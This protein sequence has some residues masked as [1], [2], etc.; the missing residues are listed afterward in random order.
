MPAAYAFTFTPATVDPIW[1]PVGFGVPRRVSVLHQCDPRPHAT[2][3]LASTN[4]DGDLVQIKETTWTLHYVDSINDIDAGVSTSTEEVA[5]LQ[6]TND[7]GLTVTAMARGANMV[8]LS[9]G[10]KNYVWE[11]TEG[12]TYYGNH[13]NAFPL[14]RGLILN[15]GV[16]FAAVTAEHGL[17]YDTDW[18]MSSDV[19]SPNEKSIIL[20]IVDTA[21]QRGKILDPLSVGQ[22]NRQDGADIAGT[23]TKYPVTNM[24]FTYKITLKAGED[25]VRLSMTIDNPTE[26]GANAEAW[27]PMTFPINKDSEILSRQKTRWRRDEWSHGFLPNVIEW[28]DIESFGFNFN[29]PLS[30]PKSGIFY[31]FPEKQG[32]YHGCTVDEVGKGVVYFAPETSPHYTKMW[33]WGDPANFDR[34]WALQN[35]PLAAGRPY[36]E[37]Y[38][39]WSSGFNFAFFQTTEFKAKMRYNWEIAILPIQ[40]GLTGDLESKLE[41]VDSYVEARQDKLNTIA[42][43]TVTPLS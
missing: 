29:K 32:K 2:T 14:T 42:D 40:E 6:L 28:A 13:S 9:L 38:E 19:S 33:G 25:F 8:E 26:A 18:D 39:P 27:L 20:K 43:A 15:G 35:D 21:A 22:F 36:S 10:G 1:R 16:R 3:P 34:E 4:S 17:Y 11:N 12:A 41:V 5:A 37:Y 7:A 31:D 23:M 30:W 24:E